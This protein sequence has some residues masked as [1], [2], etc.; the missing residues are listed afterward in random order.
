MDG[1]KSFYSW[2]VSVSVERMHV[3]CSLLYVMDE[4]RKYYRNIREIGGAIFWS[5]GM[6]SDHCSSITFRPRRSIV[7]F[8]ARPTLIFLKIEIE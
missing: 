5:R 6:E 8:S 2:K 4:M 1:K 7:A 3:L